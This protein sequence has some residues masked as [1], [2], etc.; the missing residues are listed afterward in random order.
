M[1][2]N[3]LRVLIDPARREALRAEAV[4]LS[5]WDLHPRQVWDLELLLN[6]A[7]TPLRGYM[8]EPDYESVRDKMRL[9]DGSLFSIPVT[10]DVSQALAD[11][12][13]TNGRIAL[14]HPEGMVLAILTV[15]DRFSPDRTAEAEAVMGTSNPEHPGADR[16][17]N[18]SE[19]V[20]LGG[21]V[22]GIELPPHHTFAH[23]RHTPAE[24][25][26][27]F[28][29]RGW[30]RVVAF[31]TRNPMHRA[32][33][34]LTR[35]AAAQVDARVLVH[36]VVG[37]TSPGDVDYFSR[38]RCYEAVLAGYPP[39]AAMLSLLPLAM[40]MAGPR[41][42]LWHALIRRNYGCTHLIVGRDH[43]GPRDSQ[44]N[45]FYAPY[46][47]RDLA[48]AHAGELGI[49]IVPFDE[50]VYLPER[51]EYVQSGEVPAGAKAANLSGTELRRLLRDGAEIPSWFSYP[52]VIRELRRTFPPRS[53]QGYTVF[54]T[55]LSGSGKSTVANILLA[56]LMEIDDRP[57]TLLDGDL[58]R[59]NLSSELGF[60]R[61]HRDLN[62][63]RIGFVAAEITKNRG[64]AICCPIAPYRDARRAVRDAVGAHGGF[65]EVHVSTP[66]EV[67]EQR[68]RKGLY[69][70][71]R[72]GL[73]KG[74]TG[75]DDPYEVPE[76]P[77]LAL[78]TSR[79]GAEEAAERVMA[80]LRAEG[81][82]AGAPA[83]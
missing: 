38:V 6:G 7:F 32:H 9:A 30:N 43:A 5:S 59:K 60:S 28:A 51:G 36:P 26:A 35:R 13:E 31:Q 17:M 50:M 69:A 76:R 39:D 34:E 21:P 61:E 25:R 64:V 53:R 18:R 3:T 65:V 27:E 2:H 24:L 19:P 29:R 78:D 66:I 52:E 75:I 77:E 67:C 33:V 83:T 11:R 71:A 82:L 48:L 70:K 42:A 81:Y 46:A 41:E 16:L 15:T 72:A 22:E 23:L 45:A 14:R 74:F 8:G 37:M 68:D 62:I 1:N 55:G 56:R 20:Y 49:G 73:V 4:H 47:A 79:L 58:V 40:R 63:L 57:V 12:I 44:G 80:H 54:F 10:L